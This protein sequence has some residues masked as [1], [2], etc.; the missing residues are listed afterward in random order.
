MNTN[1]KK[2]LSAAERQNK[3]REKLKKEGRYEEYKA[4]HANTVKKYREKQTLRLESLT[5]EE[6]HQLVLE[7]R[8]DRIRKQKS[9]AKTGTVLSPLGSAQS[10]G[11]AYCRKSSLNRAVNVVKKSLP[12]SPRKRRNVLRKLADEFGKDEDVA[13]KHLLS[14]AAETI[15]AVKNFYTR[16]D[17]SRMA[18]G[19]R[20]VVTIKDQ[21]GKKKL[22]KRHLYM[23]IKETYGVFKDENPN[24]KIGLTKFSTLRPPNVLL[25][26]QTPSNVCTC[27]YHQNMFL[28]LDAIHSHVPGIPVYST[29]FSASC[30]LNPESDLCWFGNC[31]HD[32]C[33]FEEKYPL[34][35]TV[36]NLPAKW[37]KWQEANG[38]L[39]KLENTGRV[40]DL[41]DH[42][43]SM[44][45][46]L[47][48]CHIKRL[49]SKQY[50]LDKELASLQDSD[51][52]VLQMDF[53]ENYACIAQDEIQSAHWNQNQVTLFTT[54]T[55]LKGEVMSKVIVSDCMQHTKSSVMVFLDEILKNLPSTVKE[56]RIWTDGPSSQF[57]NKFVM[58]GMRM[59]SKKYGVNLEWNFSATSHGKGPVDGI[60][61]CLKRKATNRVKMRQ[62]VINN[63]TDFFKAV[64]EGSQIVV[65]FITA[66]AVQARE[67]S[68][69]L[70]D[71][72][73][74][75]AQI[76][77]I[78]QYHWVG[79]N[80][81]GEL[82]TK[83]YSAAEVST[84]N[85]IDKSS[86]LES[87]DCD[88]RSTQDV[89]PIATEIGQWYAV[90]WR[91]N[92]YWFIGRALQI[93]LDGRVT[94]E[95]VHQTA[96][97]VNCF[98]PTNDI[99]T[100]PACDILIKIESPTPLSSSR[101]STVKFTDSEYKHVQEAFRSKVEDM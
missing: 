34:P 44:S 20:D 92:N 50:E 79:I 75:A 43:C 18:P 101:C 60:G 74:N 99:D 63:A 38:R 31:S 29:D 23:S 36:K 71:V 70:P 82:T 80:R 90:Y 12:A 21:E 54:V 61:G 10:S 51:I 15:E 68:L 11:K 65:T 9:R 25:S 100:V 86:D 55:W 37:M 87:S 22:Q 46:F 98:K 97:D 76:Q 47:A 27:V 41:Y 96:E 95:F 78:S 94:M 33:G 4:K 13:T 77:G 49:Q 5:V 39:A 28:A 57:K 19:K 64:N 24:V 32:G 62:C 52:A 8:E 35:D 56:V 14:L 67:K 53:A 83:R 73:A 3:R 40:Q 59:L 85:V 89:I 93:E 26:S 72:F 30:V 58:E 84:N 91:P 7:R 16:D 17:I 42:I 81:N 69:G 2:P 88:S 48:H 6:K 1:K 66:E 45:K